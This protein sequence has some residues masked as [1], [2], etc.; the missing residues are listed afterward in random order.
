MA[1]RRPTDF[2]GEDVMTDVTTHE[3]LYVSTEG[4]AGA[5][6]IVPESQLNEIRRLL[7]SHN[8]RYTVDD[9]AIALDGKPEV[10]F[11]ELAVGTDAVSVQTLLDTKP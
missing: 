6:I 8:V 5:Y 10:T 2:G 3:R 4:T 7:D 11:V 1:Q 9:D